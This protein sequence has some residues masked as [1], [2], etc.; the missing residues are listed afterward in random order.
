M[1]VKLKNNGLQ[2]K[3]PTTGWM[4]GQY[5]KSN[6]FKDIIIQ[7][8]KKKKVICFSLP[9]IY[10]MKM[11]YNLL[12]FD[13]QSYDERSHYILNAIQFYIL[14]HQIAGGQKY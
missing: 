14:R 9:V 8:K 4:K 5:F 1:N 12:Q 6:A 2:I 3:S 11:P 13:H 7:K 10:V